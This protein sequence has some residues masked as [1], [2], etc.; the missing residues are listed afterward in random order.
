MRGRG[1][2]GSGYY[3]GMSVVWFNKQGSLISTSIFHRVGLVE[4]TICLCRFGSKEILYLR[5]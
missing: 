5:T 1:R 4:T 2:G 3:G